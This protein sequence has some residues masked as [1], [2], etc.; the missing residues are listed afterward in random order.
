MQGL[1]RFT[2]EDLKGI[3]HNELLQDQ[4]LRKL[5]AKV[6]EWI[7]ESPR[8]I[9]NNDSVELPSSQLPKNFVATLV[10][11]EELPSTPKIELTDK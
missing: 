1:L 8:L 5:H 10:A 9:V 11:I 6:V 3:V 4:L 7:K 2:R